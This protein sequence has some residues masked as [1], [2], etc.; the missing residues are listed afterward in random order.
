MILQQ[1][2]I[3]HGFQSL[4]QPNTEG[5]KINSLLGIEIMSET[6]TAR[7]NNQLPR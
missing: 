7:I 4:Q 1:L 5:E 6:S 3:F 2:M